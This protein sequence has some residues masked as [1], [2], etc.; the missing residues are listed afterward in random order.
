MNPEYY[1]KLATVGKRSVQKPQL[2]LHLK[3]SQH[4]WCCSLRFT[5]ESKKGKAHKNKYNF[6]VS[7]AF[8]LANNSVLY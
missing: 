5:S 8:L 3:K 1:I 6:P 4:I 2:Y 7:A